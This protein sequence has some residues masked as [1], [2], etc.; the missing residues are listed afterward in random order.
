M[1]GKE[2]TSPQL[3]MTFTESGAV[4]IS[5]AL[6]TTTVFVMVSELSQVNAI[7]VTEYVPAAAKA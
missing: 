7:N 4:E 3:N 1:M 5:G 6:C 2:A